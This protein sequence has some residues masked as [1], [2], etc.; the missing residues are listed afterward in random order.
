MEKREIIKFGE[1]QPTTVV[2]DTEP[3]EAKVYEKDTEWGHKKSFGYFVQGDKMFF[4]SEALHAKLLNYKRGDS[5]LINFVEKRWVLSLSSNPQSP[6]VSSA[7]R[8]MVA[9]NE[10]MDLLKQ[11]KTGVD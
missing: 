8:T 7:V 4:A 9:N 5:V 11:I 10:M 2:L 6:A 3:S 1:N